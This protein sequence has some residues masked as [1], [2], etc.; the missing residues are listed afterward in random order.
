MS[1]K[2]IAIEV[3]L[4]STP[5]WDKLEEAIKDCHFE[6]STNIDGANKEDLKLALTNM[7]NEIV[8]GI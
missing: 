3:A 8:D 6:A 1:S 2:S 7:V 4:T 5:V